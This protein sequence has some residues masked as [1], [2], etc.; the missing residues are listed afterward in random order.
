ML[1]PR[2]T[3]CLVPSSGSCLDICRKLA[4]FICFEKESFFEVVWLPDQDAAGLTIPC[5]LNSE[6]DLGARPENTARI[7]YP[8]WQGDASDH[9]G[10][11][12]GRDLGPK[13]GHPGVLAYSLTLMRPEKV[14]RWM[15]LL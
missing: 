10:G 8:F 1:W 15:V 13:E 5:T 14:D 9:P 11:A 12:V 2:A 4:A 3:E 6:D 7:K